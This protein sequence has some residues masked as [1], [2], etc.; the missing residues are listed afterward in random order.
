MEV[1]NI[2]KELELAREQQRLNIP[3]KRILEK[4]QGIPSDIEKLQRRWFWELLQNASDYNDEVEVILELFPDKVIFKHNGKPFRPI[5]T[6]NLIAPDSGKD[7][8]ETRTEDM[9]GQFGTGFISTHVLSSHITVNGII[10]SEHVDKY[11]KFQFTLDRSGFTDKEALKIAITA[12]SNELN[13]SVEPTEFS[14]GTFDTIFTYDLNQ[15]LP[16]I[17]SGLAV[18]AGL[19]YVYEVLPYTLAFM[20]KVKK[21]T[22]KNY[23][24]QFVNYFGRSFSPDRNQSTF[25]V[26]IKTKE[27]Q[28]SIIIEE[29]RFFEKISVNDAVVVV[30]ILNNSIKPYPYKLTKLFCS[31][32]MIGTEEF[33][34]PIAINSCK[35]VPKTERDGIKLSI[36]DSVNRSALTSASQAYIVLVDKLIQENY[37]GF[38]NIIKW[39][40][41]IGE[42]AEKKWF[43]ENVITPIK[44]HLL[45]SEI[46]RTNTARINLSQTKIPYFNIDELKKNQLNEFYQLCYEFMPDLVPVHSDFKHWFNSLDFNVFKNCKYE[47]LELLEEVNNLGNLNSLEKKITDC[48][49]WLV[50]LVKMTIVIEPNL[51]DQYKIIPNQLGNFVFRKDDIFYDANLD[52]NLI[53]IHDIIKGSSYREILLHKDF[54]IIDNLL[55]S[56]R[57]KSES[58]LCKSIDDVFSEFPESGRSEEQFQKALRLMF[59]WFSNSGKSETSLK[60]LFKWFYSKKPQLFLETFDDE[61]RDKVFAISQSGKL[62]SLSQL[63][64]SDITAE[65]LNILALNIDNVMKLAT[66]LSEVEGG[67]EL[68]TQ[69]AELLKEDEENF[70]FKKAIGE[71]IERVFK[72]TLL[73][74]GISAEIK[75]NGW[76]AND[77]EI[78]N[79]IN[80][81]SYFIELKSIAT[82]HVGNLK[83]SVAQAKKALSNSSNYS[84]SVLHRPENIEL[85]NEEYIKSNIRSNNNVS[86]FV[87]D[88]INDYEKITSIKSSNRLHLTFRDEIRVNVNKEKIIENSD[89]FEQLINKIKDFIQ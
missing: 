35:F 14:A 47:L 2:Q 50:R 10:K 56:I 22:I 84:L 44:N 8:K 73:N 31:L 76:S 71:S 64:E 41:F 54:E 74:T 79:P 78:K 69:Y 7:D 4:I 57:T 65:E 21:V 11:H 48:T 15:N 24:T 42:E 19:A 18:A 61:D 25:N 13:E 46:V 40:Y 45:K 60:E 36:N 38:Y 53:E 59:K 43:L 49:K 87:S 27:E 86:I 68:L 23:N 37:D 88:G 66:V 70:Q 6:E 75:H 16:G 39:T 33:S 82:N 55:T 17:S 34:S 62:D 20:P 32:P 85:V 3:A 83:L 30:E 28:A 5:D 72:E 51:L 80:G 12:A 81:K 9:I 29:N 77:F 26:K 58:D 52:I 63:A 89:S 67:L 1:N